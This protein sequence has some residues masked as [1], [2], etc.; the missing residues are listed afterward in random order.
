MSGKGRST[1]ALSLRDL[2]I[3]KLT[4]NRKYAPCYQELDDYLNAVARYGGDDK[5]VPS[6]IGDAV[7]NCVAAKQEEVKPASIQFHLQRFVNR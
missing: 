3:T 2:K 7:Q 6:N 4:R 5:L 1:L